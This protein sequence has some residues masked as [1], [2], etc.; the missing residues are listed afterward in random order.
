MSHNISYSKNR[1]C[2]YFLIFLSF[3]LSMNLWI[4]W[5]GKLGRLNMI[6]GLLSF[7]IIVKSKI[8]LKFTKINLFTFFLLV[9]ADFSYGY[10]ADIF[11]LFHFLPY[12]IIICLSDIDKVKCLN[13]ITKWYGYLMIP[14][15]IIYAATLVLDLPHLGFQ[16]YYTAANNMVDAEYGHCK[17][18]IFYM[19]SSVYGMRFNGPF[20]EPGHLGMISAFLL[21]VNR[22]NFRKKGMW[23]ILLS[24]LCSLSLA[25]YVLFFISFLM[26]AY[27]QNKIK[28]M[29]LF[30]YSFLFLFLYMFGLYYNNGDNLLYNEILSRLEYDPEKGFTG[31][32][33]VT[34][35]VDIYYAA[36]WLDFH[37]LL[38]GYPKDMMDWLMENG[39]RGTGFYMSMCIHGLIGTVLSVLFYFVYVMM[40]KIKKYA[41]L[42]LIFVLLMFWQR[43]YPLWSS[44]IICFIYGIT[45]ER[46]KQLQQHY[47]IRNIE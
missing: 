35:T 24:L 40:S 13:Y 47:N 43:N 27:Y 37:T 10:Q 1:K 33:R 38:W 23:G 5:G 18:Y 39:A 42:C 3:L 9:V 25:G 11:I 19:K 46:Y 12:F 6:I 41:L 4:G 32:N 31:N 30:G 34:N 7:L 2:L 22:F 28:I 15:L 16:D 44:W 21:F 45:S 29:Y 14:S 36:L 8:R 26:N 17:N 20:L